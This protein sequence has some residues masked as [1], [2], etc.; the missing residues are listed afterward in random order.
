MKFASRA[1]RSRPQH[2]L[3]AADNRLKRSA[4]FVVPAQGSGLG[5]CAGVI[6]SDLW[7]STRQNLRSDLGVGLK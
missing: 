6:Y 5:W 4:F 1:L 7:Q 2:P 3:A